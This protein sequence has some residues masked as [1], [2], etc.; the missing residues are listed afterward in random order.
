MKRAG[1]F[2]FAV[3]VILA[4]GARLTVA[5]DGS[6]AVRMGS[7]I[8]RILGPWQPE[9]D[10]VYDAGTIARHI[11]ADGWLSQSHLV[12]LLVSRCFHKD[13]KPDIVVDLFD[14]GKPENALGV[15]A[16]ER[17]GAEQGIGR[18]SAYR[19]GLLSFWKGCYFVSV[20]T[21]EETPQTRELVL[22]LGREIASAIPNEEPSLD[23]PAL[24]PMARRDRMG[25]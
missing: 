14:L 25:L 13:G 5:Q 21:E 10:Q 18:G 7:F 20:S 19:A 17:D 12:K 3:A 16:H 8:P 4:A 22:E 11:A 23:L 6:Q 1:F 24:A 2:V 15:F 9:A